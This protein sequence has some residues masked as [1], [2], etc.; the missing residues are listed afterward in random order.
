MNDVT[1]LVN[2]CD[3]YKDAW[4]PFFSL[5]KIHWPECEKYHIVLN[6]ETIKYSCDYLCIETICGG[7]NVSWSKRL[8]NVLSKI[9]TEYVIYF[10]ED[11]FLM[12]PVSEESIEKALQLM[13]KDPLVGYIGLK[14]NSN[15]S[16]IEEEKKKEKIAQPFLNKDDLIKSHRVN[17]MTALWRKSWLESLIRTHETPWEFEIYA[18]KRSFRTNKKVMII[19]NTVLPPVFDYCVDLHYGYGISMK[20]WLPKNRTLFEKYG[21][22]ANFD[23][24]GEFTE[25]EIN[26]ILGLYSEKKNF[27][28]IVDGKTVKSERIKEK[29]YV[30]K[31]EI[32]R[33][34]RKVKG[35]YRK[36]RSV[37]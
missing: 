1:I 25:E 16:F 24:L 23:G 7:V 14:K 31:K 13:K 30:V 19:N 36:I 32:V 11:F 10:L 3:L 2:S 12:S 6:T 5:L 22:E 4:D 33:L 21:I 26:T 37:I 34:P 29:L 27:E 35:V 9:Q 18:S 20:K 15:Y 28:V 17:S 8:K